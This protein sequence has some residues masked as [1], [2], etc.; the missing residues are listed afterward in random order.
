MCLIGF[1][2]SVLFVPVENASN[3]GR[4]KCDFCFC[5]GHSLCKGE[6]QGHVAVNA[7]LL[8]QLPVIKQTNLVTNH[9]LFLSFHQD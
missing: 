7:V 3:K 5:A 6:Q 2:V 9:I 4:D 8:L 1:A